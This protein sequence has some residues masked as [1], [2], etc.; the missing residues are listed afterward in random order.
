[1]KSILMYLCLMGMLSGKGFS[2]QEPVAFGWDTWC[3]SVFYENK[4]EGFWLCVK[5]GDVTYQ[6]ESCDG[7]DLMAVLD[8]IERDV[9]VLTDKARVSCTLYGSFQ[10]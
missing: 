8:Q 6:A 7:Q 1:M 5:I 10:D 2:E 3:P 9:D 4:E